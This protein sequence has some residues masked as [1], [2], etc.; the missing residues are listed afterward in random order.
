MAAPPAPPKPEIKV[1]T[2]EEIASEKSKAELM[3]FKYL[4]FINKGGINEVFLSKDNELISTK[5]GE[6]I[7]GR[8]LIKDINPNAVII[9]DKETQIEQVVNL[10][11]G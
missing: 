2:P 11:G 1:P 8:Y 10:S 5:K 6:V 3:K 7:K 9:Q 4:G